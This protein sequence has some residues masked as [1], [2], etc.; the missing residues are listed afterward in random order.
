MKRFILFLVLFYS[1]FTEASLGHE[2]PL[3]Y[4]VDTT[5]LLRA[6]E[7]GQN[8]IQ[9]NNRARYKLQSENEALEAELLLEEKKL[10]ELRKTLPLKDFRP[11]AVEFDNKVTNIRREQGQKEDKLNNNVRKQ[12][13]SFYKQIYPILYELLFD[14]GGLVLVDQRNVILSVSSIDITSDAINLI[15]QKLGDGDQ[16]LEEKVNE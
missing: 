15:N 12:E 13:A 4:T 8:I 7:F 2:K 14:L 5:K 6:T 11:K 16:V 9:S 10:S 1:V 3:L